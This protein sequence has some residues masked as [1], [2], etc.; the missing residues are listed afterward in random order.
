MVAKKAWRIW[1]VLGWL[2]THQRSAAACSEL[3]RQRLSTV[4]DVLSPV[5]TGGGAGSSTATAPRAASSR[6]AC[7][8]TK[9]REL[10]A[11]A[12]NSQ[13][14]RRL[15]AAA[16]L[17]HHE[18]CGRLPCSGSVL[19]DGTVS[20]TS[21]LVERR[22][23]DSAGACSERLGSSVPLAANAAPASCCGSVKLIL[24]G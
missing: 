14:Y 3:I 10:Q 19:A 13:S 18:V 16:A 9:Y 11:P 5:R 12:A 22:A 2:W 8:P 23:A 6:R 4:L 20:L 1:P 15:R 24:D 21:R 17:D 7:T